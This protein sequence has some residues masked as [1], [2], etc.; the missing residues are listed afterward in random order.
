MSDLNT[1]LRAMQLE[2]LLLAFAFLISYPLSLSQYVGVRG[3]S[4]AAL[5]A[6]LAA[7]GFSAMTSP[8]LHGVM[9]LGFAVVGMGLFI[10]TVWTLSAVLG[11]VRVAGPNLTE[12]LVDEVPAQ[13]LGDEAPVAGVRRVHVHSGWASDARPRRPR[14]AFAKRMLRSAH[15]AGAE[16]KARY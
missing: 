8:W 11:V 9:L 14:G 13:Q 10:A 5:A 6:L 3:R 15:T 4:F 16:S 2:Q 1:S 7:I 12:A